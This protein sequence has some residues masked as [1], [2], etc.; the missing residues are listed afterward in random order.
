V[1]Q[2]HK[3]VKVVC[4][5]IKKYSGTFRTPI[6]RII[7]GERRKETIHK[8]N[9]IQLKLHVEKVYFSP[10]SSNERKR[11]T[12]LIKPGESVLVMVSG[13]APYPIVIAKN[14]KAESISAIEIN[15]TAHAYAE[16][17][18]KLNKANN[19]RLYLG[20][21]NDIIPK[22]KNKFDRILMPL[23]KSADNFLDTA[24]S[25]GKKGATI[26]F[27]DFL[28]EDDIPKAAVKKIEKA[29]KNLNRKYKIINTV[30]CGQFSPRTFR[31][32]VDFVIQ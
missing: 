29:C 20:D 22:L 5:K 9:N 25:A 6:L 8:E 23:P 14:T 26:H 17:N 31:V 16:E 18:V 19:I 30:K 3:N 27:Y 32:C 1:L 12:T 10:R 15:P 4:K 13:C 24:I 28:H 21:V 11:I 2:L 7:A